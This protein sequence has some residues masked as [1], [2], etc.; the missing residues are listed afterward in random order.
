MLSTNCQTR[1]NDVG[2]TARAVSD[3]VSYVKTCSI[4]EWT[5]LHQKDAGR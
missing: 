1:D 3:L 2:L 4:G 5:D